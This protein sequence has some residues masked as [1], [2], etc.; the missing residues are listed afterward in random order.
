M[1]TIVTTYKTNA[2][3]K[4]QVIA[5]GENKQRT[6]TYDQSKSIEWNHGAAAGTLANVLLSPV[7]QAKVRHPSGAQR[8]KHNPRVDQSRRFCIDV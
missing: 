2:A 5:K 8:V 7:Q 6:V 4:G 1:L 3:G